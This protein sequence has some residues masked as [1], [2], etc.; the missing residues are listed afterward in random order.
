V[1]T[2]WWRRK[3]S[4]YAK[5][6]EREAFAESWAAYSSEKYVEGALPEEVVAFFRK[7]ILLWGGA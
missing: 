4:G 2:A 6:N 5:T 3:V 1:E 7:L